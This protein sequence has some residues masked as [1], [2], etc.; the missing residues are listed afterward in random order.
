MA[1]RV[2]DC[3][4]AGHILVSDEMAKILRQVGAWADSVEDLGE[5]EVKH[6]VRL[7]IHNLVKNG[8]GNPAAPQK[9][10]TSAPVR[11]RE[12]AAPVAGSQVALLYKRNA[13][14]DERLLHLLETRLKA[15]GYDV[16]VDRHLMVGVEWG[17]G[18]RASRQAP[19][20]P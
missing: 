14:P 15:E 17:D 9:M 10:A 4:D 1:Q 6:G 7:R 5:V 8:L 3:G 2:M 16:F 11:A 18:D 12:V 20:M 19:R 13:Q